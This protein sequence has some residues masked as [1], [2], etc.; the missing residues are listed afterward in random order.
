MLE[1]AKDEP[2]PSQFFFSAQLVFGVVREGK[3]WGDLMNFNRISLPGPGV[4]LPD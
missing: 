2:N 4:P 3:A 1:I